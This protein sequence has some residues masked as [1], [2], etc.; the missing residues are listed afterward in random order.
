MGLPTRFLQLV[1]PEFVKLEFADLTGAAAEYHPEGHRMIF[2]RVLSEGNGG[3]GFRPVRDI[4]NQDLA[5][6]Y[7]EL[8]HA[9]FDYI[10]F[11]AGTPH[12]PSAAARLHADA[13]RLLACR[14]LVVDV[15]V[16][17]QQ[18]GAHRK[19]RIEQRRI[20]DSEGWDALNETWG[21]FIGWTIWNKLEVTNRM[22]VRWDWEA[23]EK[24]L[25]RLEEAYQNGDL[26]GYF[27][28]ADPD[29]RKVIPRWY[30]ASSNA[31]S[32]P[33]IALLLEVILEASPAMTQ[34]AVNWIA[35]DDAAPARTC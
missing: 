6:I 9:Y 1:P 16:G 26:A 19:P 5:T 23:T 29:A 17:P 32:L 24:F 2:N 18:K 31:I 28:P 34:L 4:S 11:A 12:M 27:E 15:V 20:A 35:S 30:L 33:E 10:D 22:A 21:V 13:E 7:H 25:N 8:F 14:Y 3:K